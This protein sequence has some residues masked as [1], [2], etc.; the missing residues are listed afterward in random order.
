M[1]NDQG[2]LLARQNDTMEDR[3]DFGGFQQR[4]RG[5]LS[6][7]MSQLI[8]HS[9]T[10]HPNWGFT[11]G[12]LECRGSFN[13]AQRFGKMSNWVMR[14]FVWNSFLPFVRHFFANFFLWRPHPIEHIQSHTALWHQQGQYYRLGQKVVILQPHLRQST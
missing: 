12:G 7:R 13:Y 3:G 11:T 10:S 4:A 2:I 14:G 6:R 1:G 5:E 9:H 8:T